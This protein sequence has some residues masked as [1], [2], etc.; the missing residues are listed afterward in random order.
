MTQI[1]LAVDKQVA[2]AAGLAFS[3]YATMSIGRLT[4]SF[5]LSLR[6]L[7]LPHSPPHPPPSHPQL[8]RKLLKIH[9]HTC[10]L[11]SLLLILRIKADTH[12]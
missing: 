8:N 1:A 3:V 12:A 7:S 5:S 6:S 2:H 4:S 9:T 11:L 10:T